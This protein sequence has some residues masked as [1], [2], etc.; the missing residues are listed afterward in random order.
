[1]GQW[2]VYDDQGDSV[3][4]LVIDIEKKILP[5]NL[6]ECKTY[7]EEKINEPNAFWTKIKIYST[8]ENER[9]TNDRIEY[10]KS[11]L[12]LVSDYVKKNI[13][14]DKYD[15]RDFHI[16]GIAIHAA[17]GWRSTSHLPKELPKNYPE[18]LRKEA[19]KAS[20][21]QLDGLCRVNW[22]SKDIDVVCKDLDL[23]RWKDW[24]R[25]EQALTNQIKLF[26]GVT[27]TIAK[28]KTKSFESKS[29]ALCPR[30]WY[31]K[32]EEYGL[33]IEDVLDFEPGEEVELLLLHRNIFDGTLDPKTNKPKYKYTPTHF[34]RNEK[35]I[36]TH[37][38]D[39]RGTLRLETKDSTIETKDFEWELEISDYNATDKI[40]GSLRWYPLENGK[41][42]PLKNKKWNTF[43]KNTL[44]GWR[45]PAVY[46][47]NLKDLPKITYEKG[48][49]LVCGEE[50]HI[51]D[52]P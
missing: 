39:L 50:A 37:N 52:F 21:K 34:F 16:S 40:I 30:K 22:N 9:C 24:K 48:G 2:G 45:G 49:C 12:N 8:K 26:S 31:E 13:T 38:K 4:D 6:N 35:W 11:N 27:T 33:T 41:M 15:N 36:Y 20:R 7:T 10:I 29:N 47:S 51:C 43:P 14:H 3:Q 23:S 46:W 28:T 25:R 44:V 19:L 32:A 5:K 18:W 1:M 17:R 42:K